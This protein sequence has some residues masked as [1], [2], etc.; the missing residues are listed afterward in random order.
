MANYGYV[1][2]ACMVFDCYLESYI[3]KRG[4][5]LFPTQNIQHLFSLAENLYHILDSTGIQMP[6]HILS[7]TAKQ[8]IIFSS[9]FSE[10]YSDFI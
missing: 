4:T 3:K 2:D 7:N 6:I 1:V 5:I 8:A 9:I 10:W